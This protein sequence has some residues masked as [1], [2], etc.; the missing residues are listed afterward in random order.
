VI[1]QTAGVALAGPTT[2]TGGGI[3]VPA[4]IITMTIGGADTTTG[5]GSTTCAGFPLRRA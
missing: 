4:G 5:R 2:S 3:Y 1:T